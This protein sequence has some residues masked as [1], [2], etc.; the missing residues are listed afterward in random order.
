MRTAQSVP[1]TTTRRPVAKRRAVD[2]QIDRLVGLAVQLDHRARRGGRRPAAEGMR[3]RPSSAQ[4]RTGMPASD[5]AAAGEPRGGAG[6]RQR[7]RRAAPTSAPIS[8]SALDMRT[9]NALGTSCT[10]RAGSP[11]IENADAHGVRRAAG[12][13]RR[14]RRPRA[15]VLR[16][17]RAD[18]DLGAE[19]RRRRGGGRGHHLVHG[20]RDGGQLE[21]GQLGRV[22]V[23]GLL[24][25]HHRR[26]QLACAPSS[27][28]EEDVAAGDAVHV[29]D[30]HRH[31]RDGQAGERGLAS[32]ASDRDLADRAPCPAANISST[33]RQASAVDWPS[34]SRASSR[35]SPPPTR[36]VT[37]TARRLPLR[38]GL[39]ER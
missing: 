32:P 17:R 36:P 37:W 16:L 29:G 15:K 25:A 22:R 2:I 24:H 38:P 23:L 30:R 18:L 7:P 14:S 9:T 8:S 34:R 31:R 21:L 20:L 19:H 13:R 28:I 10:S 26:G 27:V 11:Q 6:R 3:A 39:A 4:T 33:P 35:S 1:S 5:G 12:R